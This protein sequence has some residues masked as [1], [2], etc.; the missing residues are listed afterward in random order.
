MTELVYDDIPSLLSWACERIGVRRF[1]DDACAFGVKRGGKI[2][3]VIV[4]DCFSE[5]DCN[6]H[7][8]SDGSRMWLTRKVLAR[9]FAYPFIQRGMRRVTGLVPAS[10]KAAL[11]FDTHIGLK[12]EGYCPD[13]MPD[14]D[15]VVLGM[16]RK[17]CPYIPP[18]YRK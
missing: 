11:D 18:E 16:T 9:A 13:A 15:I 6:I 5:C 1:K 14:D 2:C 3:A 8:A 17:A 10:N 7:V 4:Y 12:V